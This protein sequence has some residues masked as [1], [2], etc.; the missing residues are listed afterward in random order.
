MFS[1]QTWAQTA[2]K[3]PRPGGGA[4]ADADAVEVEVAAHPHVLD[5]RLVQQHL[6]RGPSRRVLLDQ[7]VRLETALQLRPQERP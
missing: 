5:R 6:L 2:S 1:V 3:G 4:G 7:E